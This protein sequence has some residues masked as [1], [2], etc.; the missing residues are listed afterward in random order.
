MEKRPPV[1]SEKTAQRPQRRPR[2]GRSMWSRAATVLARAASRVRESAVVSGRL[3]LDAGRYLARD[4]WRAWPVAVLLGLIVLV[5]HQAQCAD[6]F[7]LADIRV[8]SCRQIS[9][10][11]LNRFIH[12]RRGQNIFSVDLEQEAGRIASHPWIRGAVVKRLLPDVLEID[13][14]ERQA[15]ALLNVGRLYLVDENGF[16]FKRLENGDPSDLPVLTGF[17][18]KVFKSGGP[19]ARRQAERI[20]DAVK[21]VG[22]A[23]QQGALAETEVSEV[24]FDIVTGFSLVTTE[25]GVTLRLGFGDFDKKLQAYRAVSGQVRARL[26]EASVVDLAVPGRVVVRGLPEGQGA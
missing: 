22:V 2:G 13:V 5:W 21:L 24:R 20:V 3:A 16:V 9:E 10:S 23:E 7:R 4:G 1:G 14:D 8:S 18:A 6:R 17:S 26:G 11:E 19:L 25:T 15:A 12:A